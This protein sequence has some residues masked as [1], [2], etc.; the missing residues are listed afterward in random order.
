MNE[1]EL[2][3]EF[4]LLIPEGYIEAYRKYEEDK[5]RMEMLDAMFKE[6]AMNFLEEHGLMDFDQGEIVISKTKDFPKRVVD[7]QKL[8]DDGLYK[9]YSKETMV[10]GHINIKIKYEE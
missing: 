6:S 1:L 3:E 9:K 5:V 4:N 10:K 7:T 8:K 2:R